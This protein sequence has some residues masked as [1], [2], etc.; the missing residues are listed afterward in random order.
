M[1]SECV[2]VTAETAELVHGKFMLQDKINHSSYF[3]KP[4]VFT[5]ATQNSYQFPLIETATAILLRLKLIGYLLSQQGH[6]TCIHLY[7]ML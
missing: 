5:F 2:A 3:P 7:I 4:G 6:A 1:I